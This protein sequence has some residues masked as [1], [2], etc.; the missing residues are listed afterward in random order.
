MATLPTN[1]IKTKASIYQ[2]FRGV[3]FYNETVQTY[4]SPDSV[5]MWKNYNSSTK[6][7]ETRP[8]MTKLASLGLEVFGLFFYEINNVTQV[9]VH[10]GTKLAKWNNFPEEPSE[11]DLKGI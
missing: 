6:G 7:I 1:D 8:G 2:N 4:R 10:Y 9:L 5:N 3:D 11:N